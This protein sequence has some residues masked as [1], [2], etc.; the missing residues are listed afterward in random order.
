MDKTC[1]SQRQPAVID[2]MYSYGLFICLVVSG[3]YNCVT[4]ISDLLFVSKSG[5]KVITEANLIHLS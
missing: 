1:K 4:P 5:F 3:I 2:K